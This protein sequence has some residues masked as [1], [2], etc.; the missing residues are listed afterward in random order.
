MLLI[1]SNTGAA[2][3]LINDQR[4]R[5][6]KGISGIAAASFFS[7]GITSCSNTS[8]STLLGAGRFRERPDG[9]MKYVVSVIDEASLKFRLI[10]LDFFGH[11]LHPR[12][13]EPN[14][15]AV[16]Q[17]KGPN[18]CEI[19][20]KASAV[21]RKIS[22]RP[23]RWF[24]GHGAYSIDDAVLFSTETNLSGR[25]GVIGIRDAKTHDYLGEFPSFGKE[26]H[27]C[28]LI[29]GGK[30]LAITNGG[31]PL[32]SQ[33][34]P[35]VAFVEVASGKLLKQMP[36][37]NQRFNTGHLA[38]G[39]DHSMMVVSAPRSGLPPTDVGGVSISSNRRSLL[40]MEEPESLVSRLRG[41]ALSVVI[42]EKSGLGLA[43]HPDGN[44]ITL[45][46]VKK[47]SIIDSF[48]MDRPR[49]V[50]LDSSSENFLI[51]A[52]A[53]PG[54]YRLPIKAVGERPQQIIENCFV[55]GSHLF[56]LG[57]SYEDLSWALEV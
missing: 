52:G 28:K 5:V 57:K 54:L 1:D 49:G 37:T 32:G 26:P 14:T 35:N 6:I 30:V 10:P 19:D 47:R 16:F 50:S 51:T 13:S 29:D 7:F 46:D 11:G 43:T 8:S 12:H 27:E 23:G 22:S 41:E 3:D 9:E 21:T 39:F 45:W 18:A 40:S 31:G 53:N 4:R 2:A 38:L 36:V 44:L 48:A 15:L 17:K 20:L 24:Y 42:S 33:G 55:T 56:N 25:D 34:A